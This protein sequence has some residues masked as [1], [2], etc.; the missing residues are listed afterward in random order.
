MSI[1]TH[2]PYERSRRNFLYI[3]RLSTIIFLIAS[4]LYIYFGVIY[5]SWTYLLAAG[6]YIVSTG[7]S[8]YSRRLGDI[9]ESYSGAWSIILATIVVVLITSS[10][11][12]NVS[13]EVGLTSLIAILLIAIQTLPP[14]QTLRG[15]ILGALTS[16]LCG[17]LG[18]ISPLPQTTSVTADLIIT[19]IAR[20]ST[21]TFLLLLII[22]YRTLALASKLMTAFLGVLVVISLTFSI[23][24][25]ATTSQ[26]MTTQVGQGMQALAESRSLLIGD[27]VSGQVENLQTLALNESIQAG[28]TTSNSYYT[29]DETQDLNN[30]LSRDQE[31]RNAFENSTTNP[32]IDWRLNNATADDLVRYRE[33]SPINIETFVTDRKGAVVGANN[34]TTDYYQADEEWWQ[35]AFI[36]GQGDIFIGQP[37]LDESTQIVGIS[38]AVPMYNEISLKVEGIIHTTFS[39]NSLLETVQ[40]VDTAESSAEIDIIFPGEPA[41]QL[42][43]GILENAEAIVLTHIADLEQ[44]N[45]FYATTIYEGENSIF[46]S[47]TVRTVSGLP[48]VKNLGWKTVI[49][50]NEEEVLAPVRGQVRLVSFFGTILAGIAALL[51]LIVA[52]RLAR[53]ITDL[54]EIANKVIEGD[55]AARASVASRDEIGQ[56]ANTFNTMTSQLQET[57]HGL[58]ERV[59]ERTTDLEKSSQKLERR[60]GQFEAVAQLARTITS[61]QDLDILLPRITQL[62][63]E[64]FGF[65]HAGLFLLDESR[66]FAVLSAANSEGGQRMLERRHSL[67]VGKSGIVGFVTATGNPRIALDAG[68][69]AVFFDNPDLPETRS[70]MALPLHVGNQIVGA[71]D[72]QSTEPNAFSE[73]DVEVLSI[74]ADE[75]SIAI[76]NARLHEESQRLLADAQ[77]AFTDFTREAWQNLSKSSEV[78]GYKL[79]GSTI[80]SLDKPIESDGSTLAIPIKLRDQIIGTVNINLPENKELDPDEAD[81]TQAMIDRVGA[82]V[83]TAALLEETRRRA[84]KEQAIGEITS[85]IGSSINMRNVL[86]TAVEE[87]GRA[88]PGSEVIIQFTDQD[89]S[90]GS[91]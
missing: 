38:I 84:L 10:V 61:I 47:S 16:L 68:A 21:I 5:Q 24:M 65:Y 30:I 91:K 51:S 14:D 45:E 34:L 56:L 78:I 62:V 69:D 79:S 26:T 87:L 13:S 17:A 9:K 63:S 67:E 27:I 7:V 6:A 8:I 90:G 81:I 11:Q 77:S 46:T 40:G 31:W 41:K 82:A 58:E 2:S 89:G 53:P 60:A 83:E 55:L 85:K 32:Y 57:L 75:V 76:E 88:L 70:E 19:W 64:L 25:T 43:D 48:V 52:Q 39:A 44:S 29:D 22:Q 20:G 49:H 71:L 33:L 59:A 54:T 28:V 73:D 4:F 72:V 50:Q 42:H 74:L 3:A 18:F 23:V 37:V 35:V 15:A 36:E 12:I 80:R 1:T 86:Q 66:Q